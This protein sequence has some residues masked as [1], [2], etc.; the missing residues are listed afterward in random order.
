MGSQDEAEAWAR[1]PIR[2]LQQSAEHFAGSEQV[3]NAVGNDSRHEPRE[4]PQDGRPVA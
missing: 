1:A 2:A 4:T 3:A